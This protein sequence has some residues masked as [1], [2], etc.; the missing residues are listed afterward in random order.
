M[1]A[2]VLSVMPVLEFA[3]K[4]KWTHQIAHLVIAYILLVIQHV[5]S[6]INI[7]HPFCVCVCVF[8]VLFIA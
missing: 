3:S 6:S 2:V 7:R 5:R 1:Q 4:S 8:V